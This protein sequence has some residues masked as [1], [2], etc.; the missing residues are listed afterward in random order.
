MD[1]C[2][3][4]T[5][6]CAKYGNMWVEWGSEQYVSERRNAEHGAGGGS[7]DGKCTDSLELGHL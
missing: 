2:N 3:Y 1:L 4:Q 7:D 5:G 6:L